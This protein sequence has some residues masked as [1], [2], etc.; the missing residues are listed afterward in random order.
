MFSFRHVE[1]EGPYRHLS[2][3][4]WRHMS[5]NQEQNLDWSNTFGSH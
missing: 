4:S 2:G 3:G 5:T 1:F